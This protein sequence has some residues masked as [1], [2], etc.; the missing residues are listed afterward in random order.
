[1]SIPYRP[2]Q[3][4]YAAHARCPCGAG[5]AHVNDGDPAGYWDC[6]AILTG[7]ADPG[8]RHEGQLPFVFWEIKSEWQPSQG[9][10]TT[11]PGG[12]I[13]RERLEK[14]TR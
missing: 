11:R 2:E 13:D 10:A 14:V 6:S 4:T 12:A 3:L 9:G 1:M 8:V 7:T 5:M